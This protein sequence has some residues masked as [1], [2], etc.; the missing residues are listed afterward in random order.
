MMKFMMMG[1]Q[2]KLER[3]LYLKRKHRMTV[4]VAV[5]MEGAVV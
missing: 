1:L 4:L 3:K 2:R 5:Q